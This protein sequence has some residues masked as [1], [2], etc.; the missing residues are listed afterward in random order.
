M[1]RLQMALGDTA[2]ADAMFERL[3]EIAEALPVPC[4]DPLLALLRVRKSDTPP[5]LTAAWLGAFEARTAGATLP[6]APIPEVRVPDIQ[7]LEIATW[8]QLRL[9]ER[10]GAQGVPGGQEITAVETR[11][12]SF[13]EAMAEQGRHGSALEVSVLLTRLLWQSG[14]RDR[15]VAV[16]KPALTR[17]EREGHVRVFVEAGPALAPALCQAAAQGIAPLT[18]RKLLA[19]LGE[20]A[21]IADIPTASGS[22]ALIEPLSDRE[23]EVLRLLAAG[24]PNKEIAAQLYLAVGTVKR[25]VFNLYG[26]L[27]ANSRLSAVA[28]ARELSLL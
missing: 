24:L 11:L 17:A 12:E 23:V 14:R 16:L 20:E 15:A 21:Q 18:V 19:A 9:A 28:R 10:P 4:L 5:E 13:L 8:A 3:A 1:L 27:G 26:K 25:H 22:P 6:S 7:G 2:A